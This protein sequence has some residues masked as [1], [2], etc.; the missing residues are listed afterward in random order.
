MTAT[1]QVG[2]TLEAARAAAAVAVALE[3]G[4]EAQSDDHNIANDFSNAISDADL[5]AAGEFVVYKFTLT[6][7][8]A[9]NVTLMSN[10]SMVATLEFQLDA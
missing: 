7:R 4:L 2:D 8:L 10:S 9:D 6:P 1:K 3:A 5:P